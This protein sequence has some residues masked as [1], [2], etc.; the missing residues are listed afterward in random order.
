MAVLLRNGRKEASQKADLRIRGKS[1]QDAA[2]L[3]SIAPGAALPEIIMAD[4]QKKSEAAHGLGSQAT[5]FTCSIAA[6]R[7][8]AERIARRISYM[9]F[10]QIPAPEQSTQQVH[11]KVD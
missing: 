6:A 7:A 8:A 9:Q 2:P 1:A 5:V 3:H 10:A 11:R 4:E